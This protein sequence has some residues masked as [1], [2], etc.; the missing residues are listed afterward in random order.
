[1]IFKNPIKIDLSCENLVGKYQGKKP[2]EKFLQMVFRVAKAYEP[3][4][5]ILRDAEIGFMKKPP[6]KDARDPK[7]LKKALPK[8]NDKR[9]SKMTWQKIRDP[10]KLSETRQIKIKFFGFINLIISY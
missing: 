8:V 10:I 6:K 3:S 4:I 9:A 2:T 7:R 1:L 5:I